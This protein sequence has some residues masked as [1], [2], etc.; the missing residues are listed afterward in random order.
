MEKEKPYLVV[1][2]D[3]TAEICRLKFVAERLSRQSNSKF[4]T[5][6]NFAVAVVVVAARSIFFSIP[7]RIRPK[8][9]DNLLL[10][11]V[12]LFI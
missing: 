12:H 3:W 9:K 2:F 10:N 5:K 4:G 6:K 1:I 8:L 7:L 11:K